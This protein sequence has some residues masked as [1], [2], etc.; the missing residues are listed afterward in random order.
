MFS[1]LIR[2]MMLNGFARVNKEHPDLDSVLLN[3]GIQRKLDFTKPEVINLDV[4]GEEFTTNYLSY[5]HLTTHLL[6]ILQRQSQ[7]GIPSSLIFMTSGLALIPILR[8]PGYCAS[9]AAVHQLILCLREQL[10]GDE[11]FQNVKVVE[12]LPPSVQTELH[13]AKHQPDIKDG[14]SFGMPLVE[15]TEKAWQGLLE[16]KEDIPVG[17]SEVPYQGWEKERQKVFKARV[18]QM[19]KSA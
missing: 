17:T 14:R 10:R 11:K 6:P 18:E 2:K 19:R 3:S 4:V 8:C 7:K 1:S 15:F 16:G 9:K 13:D 12:I 5:I